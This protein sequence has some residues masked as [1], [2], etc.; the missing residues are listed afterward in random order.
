MLGK[1]ARQ[2]LSP[3]KNPNRAA[4]SLIVCCIVIGALLFLSSPARAQHGDWLLGT[5]SLMSA[6][7]PPPGLHFQNL[8]SYYHASGNGFV[9][10]GFRC[11]PRGRVCLSANAAANGSLDSFVDFAAVSWTS[12]FTLVGAHF[13]FVV[14]VPFV[15]VDANAGASLEPILTFRRGSLALPAI[16]RAGSTTKGSIANMY[17]E[18]VNLGWRFRHFDLVAS[19]G[20]FAPT[21]AYNSDARVNVG[22]GHWTGVFGLGGVFYPDS[23][24]TWSLSIYAH[25]LLY[26]SQMGRDYT[27]GDAVPFEWGAGKTFNLPSSTLKQITLGAVGYAQWQVANNGINF[28]PTNRLQSRAVNALENLSSSVYAAGPG[29][30]A[31]TKYGL[32]SLRFYEEF[33][34]SAT[35]SGQQLIFSVAF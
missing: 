13:G 29:A 30:V 20:F 16:S 21:G 5:N 8:F 22:F 32:F 7:P 18:P 4:T 27:L 35:P 19:S 3:V 6:S 34:A 15:L 23:E 10:S 14:V 31:L 33:G 17:F 11:R 25:Y 2:Q 1:C 28:T 9:E 24:R 12:T 26:G